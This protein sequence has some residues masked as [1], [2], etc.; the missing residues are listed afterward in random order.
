[1]TNI[2][3]SITNLENK[4]ISANTFNMKDRFRGYFPVVVDVE[5]GGFEPK[6]NALL[7]VAMVTTR[8]NEQGKLVPD[9]E[10]F[11]AIDP[12]E[13]LVVAP[14]ALKF[15]G[16]DLDSDRNSVSEEEALTQCLQ[17]VREEQKQAG[18]KRSIL[19]GHN[20]W[21]DLHFLK[22]AIERTEIKRDPFHP[23]SSF[24]TST[25]A[26]IFYGHTVLAKSCLL[27]DIEF[28]NDQAH[29]AL[30]DTQKT[31]ELFCKM[32]NASPFQ[33]PTPDPIP[34]GA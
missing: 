17:F 9:K 30:Y 21:F 25:L 31:A 22:A 32:V 10:I 29:N 18:C 14:E 26:G 23:F 19:V 13:G 28:D 34:K 7:E 16:I 1:M 4:A 33:F 3:R 6:E 15:T 5:T 8:L 11:F 20:A 24:D 27:A 2:P 12:A